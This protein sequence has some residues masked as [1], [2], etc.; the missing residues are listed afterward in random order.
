DGRVAMKLVDAAVEPVRAGTKLD[1]DHAASRSTVFGR[2][3][4]AHELKLLD[5]IDRRDCR[6]LVIVI[7]RVVDAVETELIVSRAPAVHLER[8]AL[9]GGAGARIAA[10]HPGGQGCQLEEL[11][12]VQRQLEDFAI[13]H[14]LSER[15]GLSPHQRRIR[16]Y[17]YRFGD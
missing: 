16:L 2:V 15:G 10:A 7:I 1:I 9:A 4:V 3:E 5:R 17:R 6:E 13:V 14:H 8:G 12:P 11:A